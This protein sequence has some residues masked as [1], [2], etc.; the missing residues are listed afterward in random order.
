MLLHLF[1]QQER[2]DRVPILTCR[3]RPACPRPRRCAGSRCWSA[4]GWARCWQSKSDARVRY[5]ELTPHAQDVML[6]YLDQF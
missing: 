3:A 4:R 5:V 1:I 6:R 2:G